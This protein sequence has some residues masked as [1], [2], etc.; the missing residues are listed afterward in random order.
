MMTVFFSFDGKISREWLSLDFNIANA[1][2][3]SILSKIINNGNKAYGDDDGNEID[4][5]CSVVLH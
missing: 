3:D 4:D 2:G 5:F 1:E